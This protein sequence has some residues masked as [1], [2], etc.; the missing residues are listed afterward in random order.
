MILLGGAALLIGYSFLDYPLDDAFITYRYA[1]N[2]GHGLGFVYNP[3]EKI[4]STT[5]PF[6]ALLLAF[7]TPLSENIPRLSN[8]LG[9]IAL[10]GTG[11]AT[12]LLARRHNQPLPGILA[13]LLVVTN[14]ITVLSLGMETNLQ[15]FFIALAFLLY[16]ARR[17]IAWGVSLGLATI[18]RADAVLVALVLAGYHLWKESR[19]W[20]YLPWPALISYLA[21]ILSFF[22]Y[23][24]AE[25]GSPLP[26]SLSA[27]T[28]QT[29]LGF[30]DYLGWALVWG[31]EFLI[32]GWVYILMLGLA[33]LG[34]R[35]VWSE[36]RWLLPIILWAALHSLTY[37]FLGVAG[38][39]WYYAPWALAGGWLVALGIQSLYRSMRRSTQWQ[40]LAPPALLLILGV[41]FYGQVNSLWQAAASSPGPRERLYQE[42]GIWLQ[43]NTPPEA[44]VAVMEVGIIG[45]YSQRPMLDFLGLLQ[46]QVAQ[47]LARGDIFWSLPHFRPDYVVLGSVNPLYSYYLDPDSWFNTAYRPLQIFHDPEF[48]G[49]PIT[50]YQRRGKLQ[51]L[52]VAGR[53]LGYRLG[54]GIQILRYDLDR[55]AMRSGGFLGITLY[56]KRI[57]QTNANLKI[58]AH[59]IDNQFRIYGAQDIE[60]QPS[61]WPLRK[62]ISTYHFLRVEE[63]TPPGE[64]YIE[65]GI[66]DPQTLKRLL[67]FDALGNSTGA[68]IVVL[69]PVEIQP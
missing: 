41:I 20:R 23:L 61:A 2:L 44:T 4:L 29:Y 34:I 6:Y 38:Y 63:D 22:I 50:I 54:D 51:P 46:P 55:T 30:P 32:P 28:A 7:L 39:H 21:I 62:E 35:G 10:F 11:L 60:I 16:D 65:V 15:L 45:Y 42:V 9:T 25:F 12:Y 67:V 68:E 43:E 52:A 8:I 48:W 37:V 17:P 5:A 27:K 14:P 47:A 26:T 57:G 66:Y 33:I 58:F 56:W 24:I 59:L 40:R 53:E 18:I 64:Y 19:Q 13:G 31:P 49:S 69:Q 1:Y 3:G 36:A